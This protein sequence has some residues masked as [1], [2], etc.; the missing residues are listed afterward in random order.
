MK[1]KSIVLLCVSFFVL[2]LSS[3]FAIDIDNGDIPLVEKCASWDSWFN[4]NFIDANDALKINWSPEKWLYPQATEWSPSV[5]GARV[6][7]DGNIA[8][9]FI[10]TSEDVNFF[11]NAKF[12]GTDVRIPFA[13]EIDVVDHDNAFGEAGV[14]DFSVK[15]DPDD[16][17][18]MAD[19]SALDKDQNSLGAIIMHPTELKAD[20]VYQ[21][22]FY[23]NQKL[24]N[25]GVIHVNFQLTVNYKW[26]AAMVNG[27]SDKCDILDFMGD[28]KDDSFSGYEIPVANNSDYSS[29]PSKAVDPWYYFLAAKTDS[30]ESVSFELGVENDAVCWN[31]HENPDHDASGKEWC[32]LDDNGVNLW[33]LG[34]GSTYYYNNTIIDDGSDDSSSDDGSDDTS[35]DPTPEIIDPGTSDSGGQNDMKIKNVT[36]SKG[37][38]SER[39]HTLYQDPGEKFYA[40]AQLD[41]D[42][43]ATVYDFKI[44]FY[45]DGGK[46]SF[47][48]DDKDYQDSIRIDSYLPDA[49]IRYAKELTSPTEPGIYWVYACVTSID[50]DEDEGNN[51][52]DEDDTE[53]YGKLIIDDPSA[54][55]EEVPSV[56]TGKTWEQLTTAEK[57]AVMQIIFND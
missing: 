16:A 8:V 44:K 4:W 13:L 48:R 47:D 25:S 35:P 50:N 41:N 14:D 49:K 10:M 52:S 31:D 17:G 11:K 3:V 33:R 55:N 51:C 54:I 24:K 32:I 23:P 18:L 57:A 28:F 56:I 26:I 38:H 40:Y 30:N 20:T 12:N 22:V 15:I 36:L 34:I 53:E 19:I 5:M 37:A 46:K 27:V 6:G 39:F 2:S 9:R 29:I 21:I 7:A 43:T 1:I 42:G 45:I